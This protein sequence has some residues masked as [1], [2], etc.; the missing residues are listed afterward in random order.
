MS[1]TIASPRPEPGTLSSSRSPRS[2]HALAVFG[3]QAGAVV[4]DRQFP[5]RAGDRAR[6]HP[7]M[8]V[9]DLQA[10]SMRLPAI[11][12]RS[13]RSP[14]KA[15]SWRDNRR[16][17][18]CRAPHACAPGCARDRRAPAHRACGCRARRAHR[19]RGRARDSDRPGGASSRPASSPRRRADRAAASASLDSTVSG[20]FRKCA[21]LDDMRARAA[22]DFRAVLD[23]AVELA[24]P[25]ARSRRG[26]RL[27]GA[28]ALPSRMRAK[29]LAHAA[30][31]HAGR[32]APAGTPRT[33]SPRPESRTTRSACR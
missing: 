33:I 23:Q 27:R 10:L 7:H 4:F 30:Q 26:N 17:S 31:R 16:R 22:H 5:A 18:R 13:W 14:R 11:S 2:Q 19:R 8:A 1:S 6:A 25:A 9:R 29:R 20:V 28:R 3:A 21:R 32:R 12:S 24:A 15:R